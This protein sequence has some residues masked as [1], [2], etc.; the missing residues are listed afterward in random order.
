[1]KGLW[2]ALGLAV[3]ALPAER[4]PVGGVTPTRAP[5]RGLSCQLPRAAF[6]RSRYDPTSAFGRGMAKPVANWIWRR[7]SRGSVSRRLSAALQWL[8]LL[9]GLGVE[10]DQIGRR[11]SAGVRSVHGCL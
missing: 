9:R 7:G 6:L 5:R 11:L 1:M 8:L 4:V 2:N 3:D 10:I